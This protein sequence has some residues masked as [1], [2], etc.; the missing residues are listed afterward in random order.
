MKLNAMNKQPKLMYE[1]L[2]RNGLR[3]A[4]YKSKMCTTVY[5]NESMKRQVFHFPQKEVRLPHI[6]LKPPPLKYLQTMLVR[7]LKDA[8]TENLSPPE[9]V[10][11]V[12]RLITHVKCREPDKQFC[13]DYLGTIHSMGVPQEI[14]QKDY[15]YVAGMYEHSAQDQVMH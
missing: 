8:I 11:H 6:C 9:L 4:S 12:E 14:Y 10:P 1:Y 5:L 13:L 15:K 3:I 2:L 7:A